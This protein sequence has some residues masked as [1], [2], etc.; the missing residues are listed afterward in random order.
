MMYPRL[1]LARNLLSQDGSI[2]VSI[3]DNESMHLRAL[4]DEV[5]GPENFRADISWQKRYT[6]S[7]NTQDFTTVVEHILAYSRSSEF[8][9][10]LLPRTDEADGRYTNPDNDPAGRGRAPH[11]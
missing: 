2:F 5:F 3:D 8:K 7:N 10:N 1:V 9:V 11:F 4:M 6:R